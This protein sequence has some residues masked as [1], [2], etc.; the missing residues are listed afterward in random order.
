MDQNQTN[1]DSQLTPA[2]ISTSGARSSHQSPAY[3][4]IPSAFVRRLAERFQLGAVSHGRG[5]WLRCYQSG[6]EPMSEGDN[7]HLK[8]QTRYDIDFLRERYNHAVDHLLRLKDEG[9]GK[10][11]HIGAVAWFLA[12]AAEAEARGVNWGD[13]LMVRTPEED[14]EYKRQYD[15]H[16]K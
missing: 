13:V 16:K 7:D 9:T 2:H 4:D 14:A 11:D 3:A 10:D 8:F 6:L 15:I 12:F 5:N 1:G